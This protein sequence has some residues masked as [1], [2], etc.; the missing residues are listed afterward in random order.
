MD[1]PKTENRNLI[2]YFV[3]AFAFSWLFWI[4]LALAE[5]GVP[6]PEGLVTFL[7][8]PF[9]LGAWG[10]FVAAFLLTG[11]NEKWAGVKFLLKRGVDL[12]FK[13]IWL[14]AIFFLPILIYSGGI[15]LSVATGKTALDTAVLTNPPILIIGFLMVLLTGG[16]LQEEFG[17]RGYALD[18]LQAR[19]NALVSSI[20]LGLLWWLWH[21]PLALIPGK[22]MVNG[23]P[24]FFM[25]AVVIVL[26]TVLFTWIY[27]NTGRSLL[28]ALL[29]HTALNWGIW[30]VLPTMK[31]TGEMILYWSIGLAVAAAIVVAV[32]GAKR[33][34]RAA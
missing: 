10:P 30:A 25:L 31:V 28:A 27:N 15:L 20:I 33:L 16:P 18:R 4:P 21:L 6:L 13:K 7:K 34:S 19:H 23:L 29:F 9:S 24:L 11:I 32:F 8:S 22:F 5:N 2:L 14:L 1:T 3:I 12:R 26:M 17:W